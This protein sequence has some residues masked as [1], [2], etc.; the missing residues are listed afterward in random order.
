MEVEVRP[1][2]RVSSVE[3]E[4]SSI[5]SHDSIGEPKRPQSV[6]S[7]PK[8]PQ[9]MVQTFSLEAKSAVENQV[10]RLES[11]KEAARK[12]EGEPEVVMGTV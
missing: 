4:H 6:H 8:P 3:V 2:C 10:A 1:A 11:S 9:E 12:E 7:H 5:S